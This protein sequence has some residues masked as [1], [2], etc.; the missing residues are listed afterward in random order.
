MSS[1]VYQTNPD[2][3]LPSCFKTT[4][5][6]VSSISVAGL[7]LSEYISEQSNAV[8]ELPVD[9]RYGLVNLFIL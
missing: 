1:R 3:N 9:R 6:C 2:V 4:D 7:A 8:Y 5:L